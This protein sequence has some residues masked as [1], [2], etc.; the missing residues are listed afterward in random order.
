MKRGAAKLELA[1]P[2]IMCGCCPAYVGLTEREER[3]L[4]VHSIL[5]KYI[6]FLFIICYSKGF[7]QFFRK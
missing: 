3:D 7:I 5:F 6:F 4:N 2:R 1:P